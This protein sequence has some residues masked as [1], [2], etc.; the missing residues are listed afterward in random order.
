ML[1]D[2]WGLDANDRTIHYFYHQCIRILTKDRI[3]KN[4]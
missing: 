4:A 1:A 2:S 3:G